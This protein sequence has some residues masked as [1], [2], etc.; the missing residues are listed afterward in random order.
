MNTR[1]NGKGSIQLSWLGHSMFLLEGSDGVKIVTDPYSGKTGYSVPKVTADIVTISHHHYD[2]DNIGAVGGS[3][4]T[5]ESPGNFE[6]GSTIIEGIQSYHDEV[7]GEKR[8]KNVIFKIFLNQL[9]IAHMG[10][11]GQPKMMDEQLDALRGVDILLIPVGGTYTIDAE[12]A[13]EVVQRVE[14]KIVVPMHYKTRDCVIKVASVEPF[15][16]R[17]SIVKR[18][19]GSVQVS[20]SEIPGKT[21]VWVM[22]YI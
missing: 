9:I 3:P 12:Q 13:V 16:Q 6:F 1:G 22:E 2:H 10:D 21:E 4:K 8:G 14:P 5:V 19:E 11:Y 20:A 15:L 7:M 18:K 17:V